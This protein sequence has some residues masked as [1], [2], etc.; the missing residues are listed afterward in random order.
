MPPVRDASLTQRPECRPVPPEAAGS[1]P[2]RGAI[3]NEVPF[4]SV[5][6]SWQRTCF[7]N[8]GSRVRSL[9]LETLERV[10]E[11]IDRISVIGGLDQVL[12][13]LVKLR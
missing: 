4:I 6:G 11:R 12:Y 2:A 9:Q 3:S 13:G 8:M 5:W 1:S 10:A 7:G